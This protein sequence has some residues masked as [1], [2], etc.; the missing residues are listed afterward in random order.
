MIMTL[1]H[2]GEA[3]QKL[4]TNKLLFFVLAVVIFIFGCLWQALDLVIVNN[5]VISRIVLN[6]DK[7]NMVGLAE[8]RYDS[9][10]EYDSNQKNFG[11][12]SY[13]EYRFL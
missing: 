11:V 10:Y 2:L 8:G 13:S 7:M 3:H 4:I 12:V 5:P 6:K 1:I 9:F